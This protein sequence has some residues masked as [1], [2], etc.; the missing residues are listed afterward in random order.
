MKVK[1]QLKDIITLYHTLKTIIDGDKDLKIDALFKFK[2]L[3]IM[4]N[5]ETPVTNFDFIRNEKIQEYGTQDEQGR[6]SISPDN[7]EAIEKFKED[8]NKVTCSEIDISI[9]KL[10]AK[11]AFASGIPADLL[12]GLYNIMEE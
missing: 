2:L 6:F 11:E 4:K 9:E 7:Q 1:M 3:G 10:K 12:I 8:L 5:I